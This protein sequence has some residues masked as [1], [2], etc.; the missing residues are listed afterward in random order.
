MKRKLNISNSYNKDNNNYKDYKHMNS[1]GVYK[2]AL[3]GAEFGLWDW[4]IK[5]GNCI[6]NDL[7]A[8]MLG[9]K[10]EDIAP[11]ISSWERLIHPDDWQ[12][13]S[14]TLDQHF[15]GKT[16]RFR[17]EY[18]MKTS[19]GNWK[20]ILSK[21]RIVQRSAKRQPL[22][23][24]GINKD[25]DRRK[26]TEIE[27][28]KHRAFF[29]QLFD[30]SPSGIALLDHK[31]RVIRINKSFQ[32]MFKYSQSEVEGRYI[33]ELIV[34][35]DKKEEG[36]SLTAKASTGDTVVLETI[37]ESSTG[38]R[39]NVM[40]FG[41]SVVINNEVLGIFAVYQDITSRKREEEE[42][43]YLSFHDQLTGLYNRRYFENELE[44]LDR[45]RQLP[46]GIIVA[47]LDYLKHVND[48]YGHKRGDKYIQ[49]A[50]EAI[51]TV[52]RQGDIAA[53]IG[54]DE[55]AVLLPGVDKEVL[56]DIILR[57]EKE[58]REIGE[59]SDD[60]YHISIGY[61][62]KKKDKQ[63]LEDIFTIADRGMYIN[64]EN[65]KATHLGDI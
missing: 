1:D 39:L 54:G 41:Y 27:I 34:P 16:D 8:D 28:D 35:A 12:R 42:I 2:M 5:S 30:G 65:Y 51:K 46:I 26:S 17:C 61:E 55:F 10:L 32:K 63:S 14:H 19:G 3:E 60:L 22:R 57:I 40:L 44:R 33:N 56:E 53:R 4:H 7:W 50:A 21:G 36:D 25:I 59:N 20:W 13:V 15:E 45:S 23:V 62:I 38:K 9:Y 43:K 11:H 6:Y 64:K 31:E 29:E 58:Y 52:I 49:D 47:D 37:R 24:V 18:R 48:D